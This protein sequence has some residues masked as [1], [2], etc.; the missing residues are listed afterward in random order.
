MVNAG[1][2]ICVQMFLQI[3]NI[4]G[5]EIDKHTISVQLLKSFG[6]NPLP[7]P[8]KRKNNEVVNTVFNHHRWFQG[9]M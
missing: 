7:F 3:T 5:G 2:S 4:P 6:K 1:I 9:E 8:Y